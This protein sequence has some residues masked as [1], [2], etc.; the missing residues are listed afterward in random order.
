MEVEVQQCMK[1]TI[2]NVTVCL[3][4][5]LIGSLHLVKRIDRATKL[6]KSAFFSGYLYLNI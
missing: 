5:L 4:Y 1:L 6:R 3:F 2:T